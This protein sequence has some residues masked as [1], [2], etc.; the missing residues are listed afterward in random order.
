MPAYTVPGRH[1]V[2]AER[3][4]V[5]VREADARRRPRG[6]AVDRLV[7]AQGLETRVD[8]AG[9]GIERQRL[10]AR[11]GDGRQPGVDRAPEPAR[12]RGLEDA[13]EA[14]AIPGIGPG[15]ER[16][17]GRGIDDQRDDDREQPATDVDPV[18]PALGAAEHATERACIDDRRVRRVDDESVSVDRRVPRGERGKARASVRGFEDAFRAEGA[19]VDDRGVRRVHGEGGDPFEADVWRVRQ[20][21]AASVVAAV[22]LAVPASGVDGTGLRGGRERRDP[23]VHHAVFASLQLPAPS[24][25]RQVPSPVPATRRAGVDGESASEKAVVASGVLVQL[26]PPLV[27]L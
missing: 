12:V 9:H 19:R 8:G 25:L 16:A 21:A 10:D 4:D 18:V 11:S 15:V 23:G 13:G 26:A 17:R 3:R 27:D 1:R 2:Y 22:H 14:R 7:D 20:P 5:E 24:V 6:P